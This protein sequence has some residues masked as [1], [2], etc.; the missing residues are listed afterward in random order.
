[1]YIFVYKTSCTKHLYRWSCWQNVCINFL[2]KRA[3]YNPLWNKHF[4]HTVIFWGYVQN[5]CT[6]NYRLCTK[7]IVHRCTY[8]EMYKSYVHK[9]NMYTGVQCILYRGGSFMYMHFVHNPKKSPYVQNGYFTKIVTG[10]LYKWSIRTLWQQ[11]HLY[12]RFVQLVL[13]TNMYII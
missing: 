1:M 13:Y 2:Y 9:E 7:C 11:L 8:F 12:R 10:R 3:C 5:A 4:V 6:K